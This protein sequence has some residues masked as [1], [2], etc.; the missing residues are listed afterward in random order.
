MARRERVIRRCGPAGIE[1]RITVTNSSQR[2]RRFWQRSF[3]RPGGEALTGDEE[4]ALLGVRCFVK[5]L[6]PRW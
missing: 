4:G 6:E 1:Q 3:S 5:L 2:P